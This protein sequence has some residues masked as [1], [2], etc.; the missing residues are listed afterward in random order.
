MVYRRT[1]VCFF[2]YWL[3]SLNG[4]NDRSWNDKSEWTTSVWSSESW[5]T[6]HEVGLLIVFFNSL[7]SLLRSLLHKPRISL[8]LSLSRSRP[9]LFLA[10]SF[11]FFLASLS[12]VATLSL[13]ASHDSPSIFCFLVSYV[14]APSLVL[15]LARSL[16]F[17]LSL[18]S[19]AFLL[20]PRLGVL[21]FLTGSEDQGKTRDKTV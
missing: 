7:H 19:V 6:R 10:P 1:M 17:S 21:L 11:L 4:K 9:P 16:I 3:F 13:W 2:F 14:P 15:P 20:L 12:I 18:S 8:S 5:F